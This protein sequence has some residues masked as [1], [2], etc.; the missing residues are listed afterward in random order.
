MARETRVPFQSS[1]EG[2][3][4]GSKITIVRKVNRGHSLTA[5]GI[6]IALFMLFLVA[7]NLRTGLIGVGP[8]MPDITDDLDLSKTSASFLVALPPC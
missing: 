8:L 7:T 4:A 2:N 5:T 6:P 1:L 3:A